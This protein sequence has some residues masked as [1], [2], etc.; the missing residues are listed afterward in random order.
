MAS[1]NSWKLRALMKKNILI[2]KRNIISTLFEILFPIILMI[3]SYAIR[4]AFTLKTFEFSSQ[5]GTIENYIQNKSVVNFDYSS[6]SFQDLNVSNP[7]IPTWAGLS[8]LPA[9]QICLGIHSKYQP[10]PLIATIGIP[11]K[12]K[13][14]ILVDSSPFLSR[15]NFTLTYNNFKD[16]KNIDELNDYVKDP[17]Y[18]QDN[19]PLICFGMR[20]ENVG[21]N[22]NYSLHYFDSVLFF[23]SDIF[24]CR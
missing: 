2:L 8:I 14:K 21:H 12:I 11:E 7:M 4:K 6:M 10:R 18:G 1:S 13:N 23:F 17:Q 3:L 5:E 15:F 24:N 9:L 20:Y 19:F 16:F 22:Y